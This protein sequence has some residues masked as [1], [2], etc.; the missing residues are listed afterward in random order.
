LQLLVDPGNSFDLQFDG[1]RNAD[2]IVR[3]TA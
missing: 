1:E 3:H 2:D